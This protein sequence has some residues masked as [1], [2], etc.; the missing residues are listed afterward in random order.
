MELDQFMKEL[1]GDFL[2]EIFQLFFPD[3]ARR[4][5]FSTKR[6]LNK[7]FYTDSPKG[8]ERRIDVLIEVVV[9]DRHRN[10]R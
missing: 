7:E 1:V 10:W 5:D 2:D 8:A 6:D 9:I 3:L 4:L